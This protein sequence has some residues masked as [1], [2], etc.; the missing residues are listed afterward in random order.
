MNDTDTP[1]TPTTSPVRIGLALAILLGLV[2][3]VFGLA[4]ALLP[5]HTEHVACGSAFNPNDSAAV[6]K[7]Y[8]DSFAGFDTDP[9]L[10]CHDATSNRKSTSTALLAGGVGLLVTAALSLAVVASYTRKEP[11]N[12]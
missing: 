5:V 6:D 7:L 11:D 2:L 4:L 10:A 9:V 1:A 3:T 8:A 12:A